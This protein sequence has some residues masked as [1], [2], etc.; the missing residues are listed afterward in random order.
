MTGFRAAA[1]HGKGGMITYRY[2]GVGATPGTSRY[3]V[4]AT[5][6]IDCNG[7][8]FIEANV[9]LGIFD[10]ATNAL[11]R[12]VTIPKSTQ[13]NIQK[14]DFGCITPAPRVCFVEATY[15]QAIEVEDRPGGYIIA[16]QE[17]CRINGIINLQNS[18]SY[19]STNSNTIPGIINGI[20]YHINASPQFAPRDTAVI[21]FNAPFMLD[22]SAA[23]PDG[24]SLV[25]TFCS[26]KSGGTSGNRQPNPPVAPPYN[27][28]VYSSEYSGGAPLGPDVTIDP[29]TGII[30]GIAPPTT[31]KYIVSVCAMEYRNGVLI[32]TTKKEVQVEVANCNLSAAQLKKEYINCDSFEFMFENELLTSNIVSWTWDFGVAGTDADTSSNPQPYFTYPDTG[33][34]VVKLKVATANGCTDSTSAPVAVYPGFRAGFTVGGSCFQIPFSFT[35]TST[36]PYGRVNSWRWRISP[37][38]SYT[39]PSFNHKFAQQGTYTA[40]LI[41]G[42]TLGCLDTV[43]RQVVASNRPELSLAF[44][45]TLICAID[46]LQLRALGQGSFSW[47]PNERMMDANTAT[48]RVFPTD[49]T[50]YIVT[51]NQSGCVASDTVRVNVLPAISVSLPADTTICQGDSIRLRPNSLALGY[52]WTPA[53]GLDSSRIK[54]PV[55]APNT[56]TTYRLLANLGNCQAQA[57]TTVRVVPYPI[58][59]VSAD[60]LICYGTTA[61]LRGNIVGAAFT[62]SPATSLQNANTLNPIAS[63]AATTA[64]VLTA[65]DNRGCPKPVSDTVIVQVAPRIFAQAGNDTVVVARQPLQLQASGGERYSWYP[66]I[67]LNDPLIANPVATLDGTTDVLTYY[68]SVSQGICT[69]VDSVRVL[70]YKTGADILVP[71]AFTPNGDG[72]NDIMR[73]IL[74]GMKSLDRFQVFNRWGQLVYETRTGGQGW[75]GRINGVLQATGSYVFIASG[76]SF[77]NR[78]IQR[79]GSFVL[80]R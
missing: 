74:L 5:H 58:A 73:P 14:V 1:L 23:D 31:G 26:A 12:T 9:Y 11:L 79:K 78:I 45:D 27:D 6:Y 47:R 16:E 29:Q 17:C 43:T 63:P 61:Q 77:D 18:G 55:A 75:D 25:Y 59:Q 13:T 30:S 64:Y 68:V 28:V 15:V 32:A 67:G 34:Y 44:R 8:Q 70:V 42:T 37:D 19:G 2:L 60:T 33:R 49:T 52:Q 46:T 66:P 62:W 50:S 21:C 57:T 48:P 20:D 80:V 36:T 24:D 35:D 72:R 51:L 41:V 22:F 56:T 4:K 40:S 76:T 53:A 39:V 3:E 69:A 7:V 65:T 54:F 10:G 38:S 71:T